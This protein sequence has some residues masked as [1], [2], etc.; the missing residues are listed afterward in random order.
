MAESTQ[1]IS[2]GEAMRMIY[3]PEA[4]PKFSL[5]YRTVSKR[6]RSRVGTII[7]KERMSLWR[8]EDYFDDI[9]SSKQKFVKKGERSKSKWV[10]LMDHHSG[11]PTKVCWLTLVEINGM[12][13]V[14]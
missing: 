5:K 14:H 1:M 9:N 10:Y 2:I 12:V 4:Y 6:S 3:T 11:R 7:S 8:K 13:V